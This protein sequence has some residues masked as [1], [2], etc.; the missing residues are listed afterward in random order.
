M[1]VNY[2]H[3]L[4]K[5]AG[6]PMIRAFPLMVSLRFTLFPGELS[7]RTSRLGSLS[8]T[9]IN[10]REELW[11][12]LEVREAPRASLRRANVE[13]MLQLVSIDGLRYMEVFVRGVVE[14]RF[15]GAM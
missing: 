11:K 15:A 1:N 14:R 13:A 5:A 12:A 7:T 8:P 4:L 6:T 9:L 10:A 2:Q 3:D